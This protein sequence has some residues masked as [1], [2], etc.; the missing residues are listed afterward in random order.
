MNDKRKQKEKKPPL[1]TVRF[2]ISAKLITII[3]IIVLVSLGSIIVLVS[4]L[5]REDLKISAEDNNFEVNRRSAIETE[6]TLTNIRGSTQLLLQ[7]VEALERENVATDES[8]G[9]F[10][11]QNPQ[12]AFILFASAGKSDDLL[13][14][15][16]FFS[17]RGIDSSPM[18]SFSQNNQATLIRAASGELV[19]LN[20]TSL[21]DTS[22]IAFFFPWRGAAAVVL[23]SPFTLNDSYGFGTNLSYLINDA[24]D[25]LLHHDFEM[26]RTVT[27]MAGKGFTKHIW[28]SSQRNAQILYT[29]E[30]DISYFGAFTKLSMAGAVVITS[31]ESKKVFEGIDATTRRN[32]YLTFTVL[33]VSILFIWFFSKSISVPIRVL[34]EAARTI[35][36]GNFA[37][38]L[39]PKGH[40]EI[41]ILTT[42]FQQMGKALEIFGKFTNREIALRAMRGEI[43]P[44]GLP[45]LA[46][47]FFSD[48]RGFTEKSASLP[49]E[50]GDEAPNHIVQWLNE[51]FTRMVECIDKTGGV[52][53]KFIGDAIMA[54]WGTLY[55]SGSPERDAFNCIYTALMMRKTLFEMNKSR[56][57]GD[58]TNPPIHI[59]C[60]INT[61]IVTAGQIGSELRMEYTVIG[62]PVNVAFRTESL[63]KPLA[64]DILISE[65]TWML[66]KDLFI[67]E[68]M[69][70]VTLKGEEKPVRIFAVVNF[71]GINKGPKTLAS[72]RKLLGITPIS[73]QRRMTDISVDRRR[74]RTDTRNF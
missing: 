27:N 22:L 62:D 63:N 48:I 46:T 11:T 37:V 38:T 33:S 30:E 42:S 43:K 60:G 72:V 50:Y 19:L 31:I 66:V 52:V 44:G 40:D 7:M 25:I 21:F 3:S 57:L 35:E 45:K 56:N 39:M 36:S 15:R 4:W 68:E 73:Y 1:M 17:S 41:G 16:R 69:T 58:K 18:D 64:T 8:V 49:R 6:N 5:V 9:Y 10:F 55:T 32:I 51:Y 53:D 59:G 65:H 70:T 2:S 67:T 12:I 29:D 74:R 47:I 20:A 28:E 23:F 26:V 34:A 24:G 13:V 61:G 71:A 14:N 54:H